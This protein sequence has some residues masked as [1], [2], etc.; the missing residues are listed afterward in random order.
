MKLPFYALLMGLL[1]YTPMARCQLLTGINYNTQ[2]TVYSQNFDGLPSSGTFSL[3]GKGP[4]ALSNP[5]INGLNLTGWQF[6]MA[7]GTG[8][9]SGFIVGTGSGTGSS[10]Y[11]FGLSNATDRSLGML[12]SST[13]IYSIG[14]VLTNTTG[15]TLNTVS[16]SFIAKQWRKGGSGNKNTWKCRYKTGSF[17]STDQSNLVDEPMLNFGSLQTSTGTATLNGNLPENQT[18][19]QYTLSNIQWKNGEQLLIRW[20][21]T[22]EVG[23]DDAMAID[24]FSFSA[25]Y[26]TPDPVPVND[27]QSLANNPTNADTIQYAIKLGG[28]I[29]GLSTS[30]F[31]LKSN[32]IQDAKLV[33]ISGTGNDYT[34]TVFTG[35]GEGF[36]QLGIVND[37]NLIPGLE[38][39]PYFDIDT[40]WID[41][42]GPIIKKISIPNQLMKGGDT[43]TI[44]IHVYPAKTT[45]KLFQ[46]NINSY[47]IQPIKKETD[48]TYSSYFIIPANGTDILAKDPIPLSIILQ[49]SLGNKSDLYNLP[50]EQNN[51]PIDFN[52]PIQTLFNSI[53]DSLLKAGDTLKLTVQFNEPVMLDANSPTN[54]IPITIGSRVKNLLYAA[55]NNSAALQFHYIIQVGETDKDGIRIAS[56]FSAKNLLIKDIAGNTASLSIQS[57]PIQHI[58]VDAIAPEFTNPRDTSISICASNTAISINEL[59]KVNN[60]EPDELLTWRLIGPPK[61]LLINKLVH[62]QSSTASSFQPIE[63]FIENTASLKGNDS[64]TF[65]LSDGINIVVKK[66]YFNSTFIESSNT[67]Y[68]NQEICTGSIPPMI[69]GT[70]K[71]SKDSSAFYL[72]E[73][74]T[75]NDS[76]GF[77]LA[78]G[79]NNE[80]NYQPTAL[81]RTTW[82]RRKLILNTCTSISN[83]VQISMAKTSLWL[84]KISADWNNQANW[85][86]NTIPSDSADIIIPSSSIY[87]PS[88]SVART[89]SVRSIQMNKGA[90]LL[91]TGTLSISDNINADSA[92]VN[93]I[94]GTVV[95]KGNALQTLNGQ[96]FETNRISELLI[97]NG[98]GVNIHNKIIIGKMLSLSKGTLFTNNQLTLSYKAQVGSSANGTAIHGIVSVEQDFATMNKG[99]F[100]IGHPFNQS[101][102]INQINHLPNQFFH[103]QIS[104]QD[105]TN[106]LKIWQPF[107]MNTLNENNQWKQY[108]G[109]LLQLEPNNTGA[110]LKSNFIGSLNHGSQEISLTKW[111]NNGLNIIA[112]P[113]VS[114]IK[115]HTIS[116]GS[117]VGNHYWIW[118]PKQG[119]NGGYTAISTTQNYILNPFEAF[120]AEARSGSN[121]QLL[122][123]EESK[124]NNWNNSTN[125]SYVEENKY[126][127]VIGLYS[128]NQYWDQFVLIDHGA[129]KN[130]FDSTDAIKLINPD[131]N[132][133]S[134]SS[135]QQK[136]SVDARRIN[137]NSIVPIQ[138]ESTINQPFYFKVLQAIMPS[139][140]KL[141]LHDR[142]T[143]QY[144][145]LT[146]DSIYAF[147]LSADSAKNK[148][149]F[150]I[151]QFV[152]KGNINQLL[153]HLTIKIYPNPVKNELTVGIKSSLS[154]NTSIQIYSS[155]GILLKTIAVGTLQSG[156]IQIPVSELN[157]GTYI[158]QVLNGDHQRSLTFIK[159]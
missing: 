43:V 52:K 149:R 20:D 66:I 34:A 96:I 87:S 121:N 65:S 152:P 105:S 47:V 23:S 98:S 91:I 54:F 19:I 146:K 79:K 72:W 83:I 29:T 56:S 9:N 32:G 38:G 75:T 41:K 4:T 108:Q 119:L 11:S 90:R 48:S 46:G 45:C 116:K 3:V 93:A 124:T 24:Q 138:I 99:R 10:V 85:C 141:V 154:S 117:M 67:I 12:A 137:N 55:G 142:L 44:I 97:N 53:S 134:L 127:V 35:K 36:I 71:S 74:S 153:Q 70:I 22:D 8:T 64:A 125:I 73:Q 150:E 133:F 155:A 69:T 28:N 147:T 86:G 151:S 60:K 106:L 81:S 49:D 122:I 140:N 80:I 18:T 5:P 57:G 61:V 159:Q 42:I 109:I 104:N 14:I 113:F 130:S 15:I 26:N 107:N 95:L 51:D 135:D 58:K 158:L 1:A 123:A 136:L 27:I 25:K 92:A 77:T 102:S 63:F 50:I 110:G 144:L 76:T 17:N 21:D 112:N 139:D 7:S 111:G 156:T 40:Q 128:D 62:Q 157:A 33:S 6:L 126:H 129:S 2:N 39:L 118:N 148:D 13:G 59:L 30:N 94:N 31:L 89:V 78:S 82:W 103:H 16:I 114:P 37:E 100:L 68:S 131:V 88:I 132:L 120:I 145:P 84:G 143:N 101:I 115:L